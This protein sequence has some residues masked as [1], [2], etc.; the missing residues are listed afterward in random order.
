VTSKPTEQ[1]S[2]DRDAERG[3]SLPLKMPLRFD[4]DPHR[5]ETDETIKRAKPI[6]D[7]RPDS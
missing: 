5:D 2:T 6:A 4:A 7:V 1:E 3:F